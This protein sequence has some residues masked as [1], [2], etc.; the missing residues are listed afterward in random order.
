MVH[1]YPRHPPLDHRSQTGLS[2]ALRRPGG[3]AGSFQIAEARDRPPRPVAADVERR[4]LDR[5][6]PVAVADQ[7]VEHAA[8]IVLAPRFAHGDDVG[9]ERAHDLRDVEVLARAR[10]E[11]TD[12]PVGVVRGERELSQ[13]ISV[14]DADGGAS[15][16]DA[17]REQLAVVRGVAEQQLGRLRPLEV[18]VCGVLPGEADATVDLDVLRSRMEVGLRAVRLRQ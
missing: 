18:E 12:A 4:E 13:T 14:S 7:W 5:L 8:T 9:V 10:A 11:P 2:E 3:A 16:T 17:L 6:D 15:D 1:P